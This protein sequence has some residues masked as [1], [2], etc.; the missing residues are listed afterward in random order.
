MTKEVSKLAPCWIIEETELFAEILADPDNVF[1][2]SL[3]CLAPIKSFNYEIFRH[4]H[5]EFLKV[6]K[7][8]SFRDINELNFLDKYGDPINHKDLDESIDKQLIQNLKQELSK[9]TDR[10]KNDSGLPPDKEP[11]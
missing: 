4:I 11:R 6:L 1:A 8:D 9:L 3:E 2:K 10:S 7:S 5:C